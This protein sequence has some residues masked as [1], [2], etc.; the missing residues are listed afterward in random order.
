MHFKRLVFLL[1]GMI[2]TIAASAQVPLSTYVEAAT[3]QPASADTITSA[4]AK[5]GFVVKQVRNEQDGSVRL[6]MGPYSA[7]EAAALRTRL[8]AAGYPEA[9]L[10][11]EAKE[12]TT[13]PAAADAATERMRRMEA[14]AN[15]KF[16]GGSNSATSGDLEAQALA[17]LGL[18][19]ERQDPQSVAER[20]AAALRAMQANTAQA[21]IDA[22]NRRQADLIATQQAE[23]DRMQ[24][25]L[26]QS[27][28]QANAAPQQ[29]TA[30]SF[31]NGLSAVIAG[32]TA[33]MAQNQANNDSINQAKEQQLARIR[34]L[35]QQIAS[36]Q[37]AEQ[38][39][40]RTVAEQAR[41]QAVAEQ[42]RQQAANEAR[43][44]AAAAQQSVAPPPQTSPSVSAPSPA[45]TGSGRCSNGRYTGGT[46]G[47]SSCDCRPHSAAYN[48]P[49]STSSSS[50]T[51]SLKSEL[52][53]GGASG[54]STSGSQ[55][56][57]HAQPSAPD[58]PSTNVSRAAAP[59]IILP[60]T[61]P[62]FSTQDNNGNVTLGTGS[63]KA[64]ATSPSG[65]QLPLVPGTTAGTCNPAACRGTGYSVHLV[66]KW[67]D[68][69]KTEVVGFFDNN[70]GGD[71][72]CTWAFHKHGVW[73][74]EG[75]LYLKFN[76]Q[77]VGGKYGGVYSVGN[78]S[79]HI[80]YQCFEGIDPVDVHGKFCN[81]GIVFVGPTDA[82]T[83]K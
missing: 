76:Q 39:R 55:A 38:A 81:Q 5:K 14:E 21:E 6:R 16:G 2:L 44:R 58:S 17:R 75:Q 82:G 31:L 7:A 59:P 61:N 63:P 69:S 68:A 60:P 22:E 46:Y 32:A 11:E 67:T 33:T 49:G 48:C 80:K 41:Q 9:R 25:E 64:C 71:A 40:Q 65:S 4:L 24:R 34:D 3:V 23:A 29:S 42:A 70:S 35:Q 50:T 30:A 83:D 10:I 20:E 62:S 45:L 26:Q 27:Q 12:K 78:D 15:A 51:S 74:D 53:Y 54:G 73:T 37:A 18:A 66:S 57:S 36:K 8:V 72:T 77:H 79:S 28:A 19:P 13:V 1:C 56:S 52:Q 47:G 43:Q